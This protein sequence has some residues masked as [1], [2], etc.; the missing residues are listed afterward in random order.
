MPKKPKKKTKASKQEKQA[1]R[2][3]AD[4][5]VGV[6]TGKWIVL[7]QLVK[8]DLTIAL[9]HLALAESAYQRALESVSTVHL[10]SL[11]NLGVCQSIRSN[12][13]SRRRRN[14]ESQAAHALAKQHFNGVISSDTSGRSETL[15]LAHTSLAALIVKAPKA[16]VEKV[17]KC[18]ESSARTALQDLEQALN[19]VNASI[20]ISTNLNNLA[21]VVSSHL[22][23]GDIEALAMRWSLRLENVDGAFSHCETAC[24]HFDQGLQSPVPVDDLQLL[25]S[26]IKTLHTLCSWAVEN[27][28]KNDSGRFHLRFVAALDRAEE[29]AKTLS[30]IPP[31][32]GKGFGELLIVMGDICE[33]KKKILEA[34]QF[35]EN[36]IELEPDNADAHAA[37]ADVLLDEGRD[38]VHSA[39]ESNERMVAVELLRRSAE[40]FKN[41]AR[42]DPVQNSVYTYNLACV[43][44]LAANESACRDALKALQTK[45]ATGGNI[46]KEASELMRDVADDED[47]VSMRRMKW[48]REIAY[49]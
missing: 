16:A 2:K 20:R 14:V 3:K 33:M 17:G 15:S 39:T 8:K 21:S 13:Y 22:Q 9:D 5:L 42:L 49:L 46:G 34:L 25:D 7:W 19:H 38:K 27:N 28:V 6:E 40:Y 36:A 10:D 43:S 12:I 35:Y 47:F 23:A 24:W 41:A 30:L 29:T 37:A 31:E 11:Y 45:V 26:K 4:E 1:A 18:D 48:F 32:A 44:A